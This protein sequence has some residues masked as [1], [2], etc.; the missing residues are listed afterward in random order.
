MDLLKPCLLPEPGESLISWLHRFGHLHF[1]LSLDNFLRFIG[2]RQ[3]D[4]N[5]GRREICDRLSPIC[6]MP[7]DELASKSFQHVSDRLYRYNGEVF[8][9]EF[10]LRS[11]VTFC[12]ACLLSDISERP[13][14][15][16][17]GIGR[18]N[19][20][21]SAIRTCEH[22]G[23]GLYRKPRE[24]GGGLELNV[25]AHTPDHKALEELWRN[26]VQRKPSAL[27]EYVTARFAGA[28][29][30]S[31]LD[32][33]QID[34]ACKA[35]EMLGVCVEYGP[36]ASLPELTD[37][38]W[39]RAGQVGFEFTSNGDAGI[40]QALE[41]LYTK[42]QKGA[43]KCGPQGTFGRLYQWV[44]FR[45]SDKPVGPILDTL[46]EFILDHY[47]IK[48][49]AVLFGRVVEKRRRHTVASLA[50]SMGVHPKTVANILS[51]SGMLPKDVYHADSRQTVEAEPAE[52]LIA[53]LK[54][55]I[56]VAKIPERIGCTRPQVALLLEKGFLRTVVEDGENRTAR[57]K[58]VDVDDLDQLIVEMR[59]FGEDIR[60][61]N[62]GM[63]DIGHVAKAL[64]VSSMEVL[65]LVLQGQLEHVELL[66]EDLKFNSV[67][68]NV[69]EVAYKLGART[70]EG[71]MTVS[72]TSK[73]L[74]VSAETVEFLLIAEEGKGETPLKVSGRVR[75]MG[76]MRNLVDQDSVT[77]FK[78]RYRKLSSIEGYW[79][80]DPNRLRTN[81]QA[82][83][84]FPVWNPADANAEF[85]RIADI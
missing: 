79:G 5:L 41:Y 61:P 76:V 66:S 36:H 43:V 6:G 54:R 59:R 70:G 75:H 67:L 72:A 12:P 77:R 13:G 4:L 74:G 56:P 40:R 50:T 26:S 29:G 80:G 48:P 32:A 31:W 69:Q 30:P 49:G 39:D 27:Q 64:N 16:P 20:A 1:G 25:W 19:W 68:I 62:K 84:V 33:Q 18:S 34:L 46:S 45:K 35:T 60:V 8:F 21:F 15:M 73:A 28:T 65:S 10:L 37:D 82:R 11:Q 22:H 2:L 38:D 42:P 52:E 55:A 17:I 63:M 9:K 58:G 23:V 85:Y 51:Q 47:P 78:E 71:G 7:A 53:K 44:Q 57:Y 3:Q 24:S 83:G 81:L 14:G